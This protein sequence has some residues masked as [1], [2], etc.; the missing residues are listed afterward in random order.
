[1]NPWRTRWRRAQRYGIGQAW[2]A[3]IAYRM[4]DAAI[5]GRS[6]SAWPGRWLGFGQ[7]PGLLPTAVPGV[8]PGWELEELSAGHTVDVPIPRVWTDDG[9]GLREME[10]PTMPSAATLG[11][12]R[13]I[14]RDAT[15]QPG[16]SLVV[17]AEAALVPELLDRVPLG[18][19]NW[20]PGPAT[21]VSPWRNRGEMYAL[22]PDD[23]E[24]MR[25]GTVTLWSAT[26]ADDM[27]PV[28]I[29]LF[30]TVDDHFGHAMLDLLHR[31]RAIGDLPL[32]WPVLVS[33]R[34]PA[35]VVAWIDL[36]CPGRPVIR[37]R[38]GRVLA[39]GT[40]VVPLESARLWQRPRI[41]L[42]S[43]VPAT[44]DPEGMRW[45]QGIGA[46]PARVR[47]RRLWIRRDRSPH[48]AILG[49]GRL[50]DIAREWGFEDVF[51]QDLALGQARAL[52]AE[53]SHVIVP[54]AS[55]VAN[56]VLAQPGLR[57]L[58]LTNEVTEID[59]YGSLTWLP[60]IGHEAGLIVGLGQRGGYR[61]SP[62]ALVE[63][64][65][66]LLGHSLAGE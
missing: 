34:M 66:W 54:M 50:V 14:V 16:Q 51:L 53:T 40:L 20:D 58:Q 45:L 12:R 9:N 27:L 1:M 31:L 52:L 60:Q 59:R 4:H 30:E 55:A 35:N 24:R 57:V 64:I 63:G 29:G 56:L 43:P 41:A 61:V 48:S 38:P 65:G 62:G 39:V 22:V 47:H 19:G 46:P 11:V 15:I 2:R 28:A 32:D 10:L 23:E 18:A 33:E 26:D 37:C 42:G 7:H 36:I 21:C 8:T 49:E 3:G 5:V 13:L 44:I 25:N 17:T 6:P